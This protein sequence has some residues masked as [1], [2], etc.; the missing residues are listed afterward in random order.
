MVGRVWGSPSTPPAPLSVAAVYPAVGRARDRLYILLAGAGTVTATGA[1]VDGQPLTAFRTERANLVSGVLPGHASGAVDVVVMDGTI[2]SAPLVGGFTYD[3]A[4]TSRLGLVGSRLVSEVLGKGM[5]LPPFVPAKLSHPIAL[6]SNGA[7]LWV[8]AVQGTP[9]KDGHIVQKVDKGLL[10]PAV[11]GVTDLSAYSRG[12]EGIDAL[13]PAP[14][15]VAVRQLRAHGDYV[16][17]CLQSSQNFND[18]TVSGFCVI[19]KVSNNTIAGHVRLLSAS[20]ANRTADC[21]AVTFDDAGNFFLSQNSLVT[22]DNFIHK[23]SIADVVAAYPAYGTPTLSVPTPDEIAHPGTRNYIED[24]AFGAGYIWAVVGAI[25]AQPTEFLRIDPATLDVTAQQL[26]APFDTTY[27]H[28]VR[29]AFGSVWTTVGSGADSV[30]MLRFDPATFPSAPIAALSI[31]TGNTFQSA[32]DLES[33]GT[34]MWFVDGG[35]TTASVQY[36]LYRFSTGLGTEACVAS[37]VS[38]ETTDQFA[39]LAFDGTNIWAAS[40]NGAQPGL[41]RTSMSPGTEAIDYSLVDGGP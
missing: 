6:T 36:T 9:A 10:A 22:N 32:T 17:A 2:V 40:R 37:V 7:F 34:F 30:A 19:I 3:A 35:S 33:D 39:G 38:P 29:F 11:V 16:F 4:F 25:N 21:R 14:V 41:V 31:P 28:A 18:S 26:A 27:M 8:A 5:A 20:T 15:A 24:M 12:G 23:F 13:N 1:T